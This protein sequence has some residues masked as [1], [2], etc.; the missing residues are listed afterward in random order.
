VFAQPIIQDRFFNHKGTCQSCDCLSKGSQHLV[1]DKATG[2]CPCLPG[3]I[4]QKCD[5]CPGAWQELTS[6]CNE[7]NTSCS[8][9]YT[10]G[11]WWNRVP[12]G[13][14]KQASCPRGANGTATRYCHIRNSWSPPNL[15]G[16]ISSGFVNVK[17]VTDNIL[18]GKETL[19]DKLAVSLSHLL[20]AASKISDRQYGKDIEIGY[21]ALTLLIAFEGNK[22]A[23]NMVSSEDDEFVTNILYSTSNLFKVAVK[24]FW[25]AIQKKYAGTA[26]LMQEVEKFVSNI[27]ISNKFTLCK[28]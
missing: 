20:L 6:Q 8:K 5:Q 14:T 19:S 16:C 23:A 24:Q 15:F 10:E 7:I 22:S 11:I 25:Q 4:G 27:N 28:T 1:C 3:V 17:A 13:A 21:N 12:P 18:R 26:G 2:Q 9:T